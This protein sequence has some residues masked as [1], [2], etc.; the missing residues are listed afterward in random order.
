[1]GIVKN[2]IDMERGSSLIIE[3]KEIISEALCW[4]AASRFYREAGSQGRRKGS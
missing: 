1:V 4:Q 3:E 2:G